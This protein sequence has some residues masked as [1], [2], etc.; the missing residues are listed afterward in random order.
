[1]NNEEVLYAACDLITREEIEEFEEDLNGQDTALSDNFKIQMNR[2]FRE[3]C[4]IKNIP[5]PEIDTAY[6]RFRSYIVRKWLVVKEF[7]GTNKK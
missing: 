1:M 6:E 2:L 3:Q 4:G 7:F 5:H